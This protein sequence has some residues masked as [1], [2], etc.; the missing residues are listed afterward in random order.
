MDHAKARS[1]TLQWPVVVCVSLALG[2]CVYDVPRHWVQGCA[3]GAGL[4]YRCLFADPFQLALTECVGENDPAH[5]KEVVH[6]GDY[7]DQLSGWFV[8]SASGRVAAC[9]RTK[10]WIAM[11]DFLLAP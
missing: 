7:R 1:P 9:M 2:S 8:S 5:L 6:G 3:P 10:D 11:P 4:G